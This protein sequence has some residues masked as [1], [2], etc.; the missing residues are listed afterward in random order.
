MLDKALAHADAGGPIVANNTL[1]L[2]SLLLDNPTEAALVLRRAIPL[3]KDQLTG[4]YQ[5]EPVIAAAK[6][7]ARTG[8]GEVAARLLG[9]YSHHGGGASHHMGVALRTYWAFQSGRNQYRQLVDELAQ[10]LGSAAFEEEF[11]HGAQLSPVQTLQLAAE[12][13]DATA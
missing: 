6:I 12:V 9:A 10:T 4:I 3:A 5:L 7:A 11:R 13:V 1:V 2:Y 8:K